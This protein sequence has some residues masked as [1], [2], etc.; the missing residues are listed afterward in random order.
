VFSSV[1]LR[2]HSPDAFDFLVLLGQSLLG[3]VTEDAELGGQPLDAELLR[4][5]TLQPA[6]HFIRTANIALRRAASRC[7]SESY[8]FGFLVSG[9][10]FLSL[11][12]QT[13]KFDLQLVKAPVKLGQV[14]LGLVQVI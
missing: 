13:T 2:E 11:V 8:S 4:L 6:K 10:E 9:G 7:V 14:V 1:T 12:L 5:A 3:F